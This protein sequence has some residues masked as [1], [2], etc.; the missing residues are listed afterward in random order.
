MEIWDLY[1]ENRQ[2]LGK[3]HVRGE[4]IADGEYHI[5]TDVW[6]VREDGKV[7]IT[8][9]HPDKIWGNMWECTGG[10]AVAGESSRVSAARELE[11]EVGITAKP[12]E[13]EL[14]NSVR[15]K[16]RFV[17]TYAVLKN[18][19][20]SD[21]KLQETEVVDAKFVGFGELDQIWQ[22]KNLVPRERFLQYRQA[23]KDFVDKHKKI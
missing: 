13:L 21:L 2:P 19:K 15:V 17:D 8:K 5:V 9:R 23:L 22:N 7:L 10:S 4:Q 3:T 6:T 11:E 14:L 16:D 1:D 18:L 12:E 20:E